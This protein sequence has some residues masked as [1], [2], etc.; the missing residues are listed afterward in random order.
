MYVSKRIFIT[1]QW[2]KESR[3]SFPSICTNKHKP[4]ASQ[5]TR[6]LDVVCQRI[7]LGQEK[8]LGAVA[9]DDTCYSS[10]LYYS[11]W[12]AILLVPPPLPCRHLIAHFMPPVPPSM[13]LLPLPIVY[14]PLCLTNGGLGP[15]ISWGLP[16]QTPSVT[17]SGSFETCFSPSWPS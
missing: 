1:S 12:P 6:S 14:H 4:L 15:V 17:I 8:A 3:G 16:S 10:A 11:L 2:Q 9:A 13:P 7:S 5:V